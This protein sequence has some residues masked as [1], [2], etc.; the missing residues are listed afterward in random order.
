MFLISRLVQ[1][2]LFSGDTP[3]PKSDEYHSLLILL[4]A[5]LFGS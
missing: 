2:I 3:V 5:S 1:K 4:R